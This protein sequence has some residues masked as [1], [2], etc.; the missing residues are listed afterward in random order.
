MEESNI[1]YE[2]KEYFEVLNKI[3]NE[4]IASKN[5]ALVKVNSEMIILY[6][7]LG[8]YI[9][10]NKRWGD[11]FIK[12]LSKD[13][14]F[15]LNGSIGFS[16]SSL[17]S[18]VYFYESYSD[19]EISAQPMIH[20][21]WGTNLLILNSIDVLEQRLWYAQKVLEGGWSRNIL[22]HK[23]GTLNYERSKSIK[24]NNFP[25][26]LLPADSDALSDIM[27][28]PY[29]LTFIEEG[30]FK[31]E[32]QLES[33]LVRN[34]SKVLMEFGKGFAFVG[35]QYHIEVEG[36]DYYF[37]LL[38]YNLSLRRYFVIELKPGSFKPEYAGKL[39]FYVSAVDGQIKQIYD[40]P[41][42]GILLCGDKNRL[43][44]EY[45][46][47]NIKSPIGVVEYKIFDDMPDFLSQHLP[48]VK[49]IEAKLK[50]IGTKRKSK[51]NKKD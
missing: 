10:E 36:E 42:I 41:A 25:D 2:N 35:E 31:H 5:R 34:I 37:D 1:F 27:I 9:S 47:R 33:L 49:E 28:D 29:I 38:F 23:I 20:I 14:R 22:K 17:K 46:L 18:M 26:T 3:E 51:Q 13:L 43:V 11:Q 21:P 24:T 48:T 8:R 30:D 12:T 44:V 15:Q 40:E 39:N 6:F 4:I 19:L 7:T 50:L 32:R 16:P 45:S